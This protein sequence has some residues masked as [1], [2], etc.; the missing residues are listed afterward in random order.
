LRKACEIY[1]LINRFKLLLNENFIVFA[2]FFR[3]PFLALH[4]LECL[5]H[6]RFLDFPP[7]HT[8]GIAVRIP[9]MGLAVDARVPPFRRLLPPVGGGVGD[10]FNALVAEFAAEL[11]AELT[12]ELAELIAVSV[13]FLTPL[14]QLVKALG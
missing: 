2:R 4:D 3:F 10:G 13:A 5:L 7:T 11:A 14:N 12:A 8:C 9:L 1:S 6:L